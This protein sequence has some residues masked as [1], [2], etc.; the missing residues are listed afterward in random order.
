MTFPTKPHEDAL[1]VSVWSNVT[2]R[3]VWGRG[4][5]SGNSGL[6]RAERKIYDVMV[7]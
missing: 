7:G 6:D 4:A 2:R 1:T 5:V 3:A